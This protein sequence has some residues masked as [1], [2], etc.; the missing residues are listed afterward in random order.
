VNVQ[1]KRLSDFSNKEVRNLIVA[2]SAELEA[3]TKDPE[4]MAIFKKLVRPADKK[5]LL[6]SM[7]VPQ[8]PE[9]SATNDMSA[10]PEEKK[11]I[12]EMIPILVNILL[13]KN[14]NALWQILSAITLKTSEEVQDLNNLETVGILKDFFAIDQYRKLFS[15]A[16]KSVTSE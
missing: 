4:L 16:I 10:E 5:G 9:T 8:L 2:L 3:L 14:E 11:T 12:L 1:I 7:G 6:A 13:V 15:A